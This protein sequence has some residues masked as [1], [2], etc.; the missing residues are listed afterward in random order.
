MEYVNMFAIKLS[1]TFFVTL[2]GYIR[3]KYVVS[4]LCIFT[5]HL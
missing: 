5:I 3:N 1:N 2:D 4:V